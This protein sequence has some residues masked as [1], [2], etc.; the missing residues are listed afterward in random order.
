MN[1]RCSQT[2]LYKAFKGSGR[3]LFVPVVTLFARVFCHHEHMLRLI[4]F[5]VF[6]MGLSACGAQ[7]KQ[8]SKPWDGAK[9]RPVLVQYR[10]NKPVQVA[11]KPVANSNS[12]VKVTPPKKTTIKPGWQVQVPDLPNQINTDPDSIVG[13]AERYIGTPYVYGGE[14]PKEGFDCS[15]LVQ[16][17]YL[18]K[19]VQLK[20]LA[21]EQFLQG[22]SVS[23]TDLQAGDLV[24]FSSDG[25]IVDHVG[26]YADNRLFIHAPRTGRTVSYDSLDSQYYQSHFQGARRIPHS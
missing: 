6:S 21:N 23:K 15:G 8:A 26:I 20:R 3:D 16:F 17:V 12:K 13:I 4:V 5:V 1:D 14:S 19:G 25:K 2:M 22:M 11:Q 18:Q 7:L 9:E 24:F 10:I